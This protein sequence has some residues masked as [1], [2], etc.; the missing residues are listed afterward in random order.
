MTGTPQEL[1]RRQGKSSLK[2]NLMPKECRSELGIVSTK[3]T[4]VEKSIPGAAAKGQE[5]KI[6]LLLELISYIDFPQEKPTS[7]ALLL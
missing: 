1:G 3:P 4:F 6:H 7:M 5:Q 2:N